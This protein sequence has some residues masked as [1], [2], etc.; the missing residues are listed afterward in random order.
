MANRK[1]P[2]SRKL[3]PLGVS[4]PPDLVRQGKKVAFKR[5]KSFSALIRDILLRELEAAR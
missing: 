2:Q 1:V 4:L 3:K 5:G